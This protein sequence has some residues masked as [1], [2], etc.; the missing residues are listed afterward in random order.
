MVVAGLEGVASVVGDPAASSVLATG[1]SGSDVTVTSA[2]DVHAASPPA[3]TR[4]PRSRNVIMLG[5]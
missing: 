3:T 1:G 4:A 5:A 2:V